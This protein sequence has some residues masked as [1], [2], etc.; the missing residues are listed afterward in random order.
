[1]GESRMNNKDFKIY[2][3]GYFEGYKRGLDDMWDYV[4]KELELVNK[5]L[6]IKE[7]KDETRKG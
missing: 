4:R 7:K 2:R 3:E 1:M 5:N 6:S